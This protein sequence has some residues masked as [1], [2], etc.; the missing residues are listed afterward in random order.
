M[1]KKH[2]TLPYHAIKVVQ[3]MPLRHVRGTLFATARRL[4]PQAIFKLLPSPT[5]LDESSPQTTL[6]DLT[7]VSRL[8]SIHH[9]YLCRL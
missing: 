4:S 2:Y 5:P 6:H 1:L 8:S 9:V 3:T 7:T